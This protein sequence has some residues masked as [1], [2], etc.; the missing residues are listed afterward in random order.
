MKIEALSLHYAAEALAPVISAETLSFHYG[1]HLPAYV[2]ALKALVAGSDDEN[3]SIEDLCRKAEPGSAIYNN[4]GQVYNHNMYFAQFGDS[5]H[6]SAPAGRLK[7]LID[8]QCGSLEK[9]QEAMTEAATKL[10]GSGWVWLAADASGSLS[11]LKC[12]NADTP[13]RQ[14]FTPLLCIDVWEHAYYLDYQ[15]RRADHV[16]ALWQIIDWSVVAKRL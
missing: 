2:N 15:N 5:A 6:R 7:D 16:K 9:L 12:P 11:V 3:K 8:A 4:A 13:L 14:G 1:K 10:F